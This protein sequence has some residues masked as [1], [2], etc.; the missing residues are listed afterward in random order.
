MNSDQHVRR[1]PL[2]RGRERAIEMT[3]AA[4]LGRGYPFGDTSTARIPERRATDASEL[5]IDE[6]QR[7]LRGEQDTQEDQQ[8]VYHDLPVVRSEAAHNGRY[9][10]VSLNGWL[11]RWEGEGWIYGHTCLKLPTLSELVESKVGI[12][13]AALH[14]L[15]PRLVAPATG[16]LSVIRVDCGVS[17]SDALPPAFRVRAGVGVPGVAFRNPAGGGVEGTSALGVTDPGGD[18]VGVP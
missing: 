9:H 8:D 5:G 3:L 16:V 4:G 13:L 17:A 1:K 2:E 14:G 15:P 6:F 18:V 12:S 10:E 7:F 11:L